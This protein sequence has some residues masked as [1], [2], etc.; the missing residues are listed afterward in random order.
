MRL[1]LGLGAN[2]LNARDNILAGAAYLRRMYDR[3][4]YPG[5]F[6]AY[7]AGP[8]RYARYVAGA[9]ALPPETEGYLMKTSGRRVQ[10]SWTKASRRGILPAAD[11]QMPLFAVGGHTQVV[12]DNRD[13]AI[14]SIVSQ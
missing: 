9:R 5:L 1:D 3:F 10:V 14:F 7:N 13:P 2:P 4:G 8:A 11:R 6:G 12:E